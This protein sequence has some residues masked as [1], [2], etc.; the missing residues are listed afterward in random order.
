MGAAGT[1]GGAWVVIVAAGSGARFGGAKQWAPL[2]GRRVVDWC[3]DAAR[4]TPACAGVVVVV[5]A[6]EVATV[7]VPGADVVVAGGA[8]RSASV[9]AGLA[10]VPH[11]VDVVVVH[12]GA[13]PLASTGL[14]EAVVAAVRA[15]ADAALP[16]V[17]VTDTVKRVGVDGVVTGTVDRAGLMAVQT[18]QAFAAGALRRAHEGGPEATDDG[19]LVEAIGGRVVVV[20]GEPHNIKLTE[21]GDLATAERHLAATDPAAASGPPTRVGLGFDVHPHADDPGRPLVLGGV[22]FP[23]GP[24]LAGHSDADAVAHAAIDALLGAAGLGDI[25]EHFPDT[26]DRWAGADSIDLLRTAAGR[27]RAAGWEPGNVDCSVVCERPKLA[28]R[29]D[30]MQRRMGEAVGAP[31][32]VKGRRP[33]GLGALGRGEGIACWAVAVV[34]RTAGP[35]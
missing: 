30:E 11:D 13:R 9:R 35:S 23:E 21:P 20:P 26:D 25:G 18:P 24:G 15:G 4:V 2:A 16:A 5:A 3:V 12:D 1:G 8:T 34:V 6:D 28:P 19:A 32:T 17:P 27:V 33:E 7:V 14:L 22:T 31:V 29:R 10:A